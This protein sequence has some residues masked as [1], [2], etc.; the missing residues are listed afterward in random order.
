MILVLCLFVFLKTTP[1]LVGGRS[2]VAGKYDKDA[3]ID[4]L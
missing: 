2:G 3:E 4:G 1:A